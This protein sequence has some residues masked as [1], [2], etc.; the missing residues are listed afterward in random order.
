MDQPSTSLDAFGDY[1]ELIDAS[2]FNDTMMMCQRQSFTQVQMLF[3]VYL[4]PIV[5]LFGL[6]ANVIN[7]RV[8]SHQKM[9]NQPVN[10]FFLA[11]SV[12]DLAVLLT[13]FLVF[14][15]PAY[16]EKMVDNLGFYN[17]A[18]QIIL[19]FYP[20][21]RSSHTCSVVLTVVVSLHRYLGVCHPFLIRRISNAAVIRT[22]IVGSV[23]FSF[24]FNGTKWFHLQITS[25]NSTIFVGQLEKVIEPSSSMVSSVEKINNE[26]F[27]M[28]GYTIVMFVLPFTI[29]IFV[30]VK[31]VMTLRNSH[32][33]RR[34]MT[35]R[36]GGKKATESCPIKNEK[37]KKK[38]LFKRNLSV[39]CEKEELPS[40]G[41]STP[42]NGAAAAI[43]VASGCKKESSQN[44]SV[45]LLAITCQFLSFNL[46]GFVHNMIE[47]TASHNDS[48]MSISFAETL[49]TELSTFL[50]NLNCASTIVIY[51]K[52][53]SKYRVV[54]LN[55]L[56]SCP[57]L[58]TG[59]PPSPH[60]TANPPTNDTTL[61]ISQGSSIRNKLWPAA[62]SQSVHRTPVPNDLRLP[63]PRQ[64]RAMS[65]QIT[66]D[67]TINQFTNPIRV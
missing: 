8:F 20:L 18:Q 38:R 65:A 43:P 62:R 2:E 40:N 23:V 44:I 21:A 22:I 46:L 27:R 6:I 3:R 13:S 39:T 59:R 26:I 19:T 10:W 42:P 63:S 4:L 57:F 53:G 50:V 12:A 54:F 16:A 29:L 25:C 55:M 58:S 37:F 24:L 34:Q 49:L 14:Q 56:S 28:S 67:Q 15:L 9:R 64:N 36:S 60:C 7:I 45:M 30:N 66:L 1:E 11:L 32:R 48:D 41:N 33:L 5:S 61:L 35:Q 17:A 52:F 31:I 51:L 47:L